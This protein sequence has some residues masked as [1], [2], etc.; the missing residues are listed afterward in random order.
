MQEET[1]KIN[2][3]DSLN[4]KLKPD[5]ISKFP[6]F[7]KDTIIISPTI[8]KTI[9]PKGFKAIETKNKPDPEF[10]SIILDNQ[11]CSL[12]YIHK[13]ISCLI[14]FEN[15]TNFLSL[16]TIYTN[17]T[18]DKNILEKCKN[19]YIPKC[20]A[21]AS[22]NNYIDKHEEI[23]R[24]LYVI[25]LSK[26]I[27]NLFLEEIIMKL[28]IEIPKIPKGLRRIILKLPNKSIELTENKMNELPYIHFNLSQ[29]I[30]HFKLEDLIDIYTYLLMETKMIFF[31]SKIS[32]LSTTILSF[33]AVKH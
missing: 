11:Q 25:Y 9:F 5:I 3:I 28:V 7:D 24:S 26:N 6:N 22:L 14:I 23:L 15:F 12:E 13:Y 30:G 2:S 16:Y 18:V 1:L 20:I 29:A 32:K 27:N 19:F 21:I 33:L 17:K 8:I 31:S 4:Q 10:Y